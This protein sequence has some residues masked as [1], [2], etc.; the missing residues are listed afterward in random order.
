MGFGHTHT[1]T[2]GFTGPWT[3]T[4]FKWSN[5]FFIALKAYEWEKY[6][7]PTGH[8]QWRTKDRNGPMSKVMRLTTDLALLEDDEYHRIVTDFAENPKSLDDAFDKAWFKL[9]TSGGRWSANKRC[10][11][12]KPL[13]KH[14]RVVLVLGQFSALH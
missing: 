10:I 14:C 2:S 5:E 13:C 9:T 11:A 1:Y 12:G 6:P 3:T 4:P 8:W 7:S